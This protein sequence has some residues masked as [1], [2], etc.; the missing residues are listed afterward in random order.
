MGRYLAI[1]GTFARAC[2]VRDMRSGDQVE[3][4]LDGLVEHLIR[5]GAGDAGR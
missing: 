3:V 1:F 2:L 4:A 5:A